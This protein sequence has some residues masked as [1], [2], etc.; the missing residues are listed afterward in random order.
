VAIHFTL[1]QHKEVYTQLLP[2]IEAA[3]QP[4]NVKPHW[5]K[6]FT[7]APKTLQAKYPRL[8]DFKALA[9]EFDPQGKFRNEFIEKNL[10]S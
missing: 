2:K 8:N 9:A 5:G 7:M 3:L 4:F 6:L 1:K 10:Y